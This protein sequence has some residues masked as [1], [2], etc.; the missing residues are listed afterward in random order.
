MINY[1]KSGFYHS[2]SGENANG[3]RFELFCGDSATV[4]ADI[5]S[6][7][8]DCIVTSPP[9]YSLRDYQV[10]GQIGLEETVGQ[11]VDSI[12]AV[13]DEAYRV[14]KDDGVLFLNIGDTYYSGKGKSCGIDAKSSKRRFGLRPVDR[15]GGVGI[16]A[17]RKSILGIPWRVAIDMMA[18]KWILRA[19]IIWHRA[20]SLPESVKD[21]PS[22]SYEYIFMFVKGRFYHF[23]RE[24]LRSQ[25]LDED[26]WEITARPKAGS[27]QTAPYP[28][29]LVEKC[30]QIG[31][32]EGGTVLDPFVGSGTTMRVALS[33]GMNAI[34]IDL[35]QRFC[36]YI[37]KDIGVK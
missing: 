30:L 2:W 28:D 19:P 29:E 25:M 7:S 15:S 17:Q 3:N 24:P 33:K 22:H 23:D 16:D 12:C 18:R 4:L 9:Y 10:D 8:V 32:P 1:S 11:Y 31:C 26:I 34:G 36:E 21:R 14:L 27:L 20:K 6:A 37:L 35:N 13:M 5:P